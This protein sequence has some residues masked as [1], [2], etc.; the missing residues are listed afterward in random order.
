MLEA[1]FLLALNIY[2]E[3]DVK[4]E[5]VCRVAVAQVVLQRSTQTNT[6]IKQVIFKR[7]QF[8]WTIRGL[9]KNKTLQATHVPNF[10]SKRWKDSLQAA[11]QVYYSKTPINLNRPDHFYADYIDAP[12]WWKDIKPGSVFKCGKHWFGTINKQHKK[13]VTI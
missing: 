4:D 8:S 11:K 6:S 1:I 12:Y 10:N 2:H 7:K 13:K 9:D 3:A 5:L